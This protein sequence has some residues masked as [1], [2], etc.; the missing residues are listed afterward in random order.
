MVWLDWEPERAQHKMVAEQDGLWQ[1]LNCG[2]W[3]CLGREALEAAP[4]EE[5]DATLQELEIKSAS[6]AGE[7]EIR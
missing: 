2:K 7:G 6:F 4:C 1:C 5:I 3:T